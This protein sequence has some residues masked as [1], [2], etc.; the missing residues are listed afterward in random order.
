[1]I[2]IEFFI[3]KLGIEIQ[4]N[5]DDFNTIISIRSLKKNRYIR[6]QYCN[7]MIEQSRMEGCFYQFDKKIDIVAHYISQN[8]VKM[9][10]DFQNWD[11]DYTGLERY[12][13]KSK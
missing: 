9:F 11:V 2:P 1:M 6:S 3:D 5:K 12:L 10:P 7:A 4:L 8:L 13:D